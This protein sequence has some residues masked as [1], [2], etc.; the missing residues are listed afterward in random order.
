MAIKE[1]GVVLVSTRGEVDRR[2]A[3]FEAALGVSN[4]VDTE[5]SQGEVEAIHKKIPDYGTLK[6][7]ISTLKNSN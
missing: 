2:R 5:N 3:D 4:V 1:L 7:L 6:G